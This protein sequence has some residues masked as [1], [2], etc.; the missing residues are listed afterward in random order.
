M[1]V[2]YLACFHSVVK[3]AGPSKR[4]IDFDFALCTNGWSTF[5]DERGENFCMVTA[6]LHKPAN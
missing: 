1:F 3:A 6:E 4:S 2:Q 5:S